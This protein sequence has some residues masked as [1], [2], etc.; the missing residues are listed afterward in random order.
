MKESEESYNLTTSKKSS[1]IDKSVKIMDNA[2]KNSTKWKGTF[3]SDDYETFELRSLRF[4]RVKKDLVKGLGI[5]SPGSPLIHEQ[6]KE[7]QLKDWLQ[8]I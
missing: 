7:N 8:S 1:D 6:M 2:K 5:E 3:Y 4:I